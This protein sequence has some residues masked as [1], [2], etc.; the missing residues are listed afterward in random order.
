MTL[1]GF[2]LYFG[3]NIDNALV[4]IACLAGHDHGRRR[5]VIALFCAGL[6]VL[7]VSLVLSE[8]LDDFGAW[9]LNLLGLAPLTLGLWGLWSGW[10]GAHAAKHTG[11]LAMIGLTLSNST[12][13]LATMVSLLA[14]RPDYVRLP[15]AAGYIAGMLAMMAV[16]GLLLNRLAGAER[17]K[18]WAGRIG[19]LVMIGFGLFILADTAGDRL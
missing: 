5:A 10:D 11:T 18:R 9:P 6:L 14:E 3:T 1:A 15:V 16:V 7:L 17:L 12:D 2:L 4:L 13:S 19:P 8:A